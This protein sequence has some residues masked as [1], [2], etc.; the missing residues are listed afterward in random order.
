M[1]VMMPSLHSLSPTRFCD[2]LKQLDVRRVCLRFDAASGRVTASHPGLTPLADWLE[3]NT[4]DFDEHEA[5]FLERGERSGALMGAFIHKTVR[6]QAQG[7]LRFWPYPA[8]DQFLSDGLR[9][10]QG[11]GRKNA[12]AGLWW[13]G[14]KG[15]IVRDPDAPYLDEAYR[16]MLYREY[17]SFV[18]SLNG[19]YI[20]AEDVGTRPSDMASVFETTRFVSCVPAE[21]GGSGNPSPWTA[22]GVVCAMQA[23]LEFAGLGTLAGKSVAMQG[24]G[25]VGAAMVGELL[26]A[27]V[28]HIEAADIS[29]A[30]LE[31]ARQRFQ[32]ARLRLHLAER[33]DDGILA[34]PCDVLAPN[35]LG[36]VLNPTTIPKLAA[37]IV[38]GA[39]NNQL[40]DSER[41]AKLLAERGIWFVPDFVANRMG[42]VNCANEQYGRLSE[43]P[44][45]LRHFDQNAEG[46]VFQVVKLVL[47]RARERGQTPSQAANL[48]ADELGQVPHP[49]WGHRTKHIIDDLV[50]TGWADTPRLTDAA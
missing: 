39:A 26:K 28:G 16:S 18:S 13:G 32:D 50:R 35:A 43:D 27:G 24:L 46:S 29:P 17:G 45:I 21:V 9:L 48:L 49:I 15:V 2:T 40:L 42:I 3:A 34:T 44:A 1:K 33:G 30:N 10:A 47:E 7:G 20:T 31:A 23:A 36:G 19:A 37:K 8:V 5:V 38:C 25:N 14:G 11:M 6:G 41:D 22:R 4:R 12:L